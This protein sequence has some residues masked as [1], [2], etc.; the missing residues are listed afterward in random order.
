MSLIKEFAMGQFFLI[1]AC[2]AIVP[3]HDTGEARNKVSS[4]GYRMV[5]APNRLQLP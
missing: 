3:F 2:W 1:P 4:Q 5:Q